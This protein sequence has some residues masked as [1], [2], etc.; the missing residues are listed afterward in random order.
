M[1]LLGTPGGYPETLSNT[2]FGSGVVVP[3]VLVRLVRDVEL[4]RL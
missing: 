4:N 1:L 3:K 2:F